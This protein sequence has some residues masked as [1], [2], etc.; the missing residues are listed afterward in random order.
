MSK[1]QK[2]TKK[3]DDN[4]NPLFYETL[5]LSYEAISIKD[6]PPFLL[7]VYDWDMGPMGDDF[8]A[9]CTISIDEAAFS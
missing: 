4:L 5:E 6:M 1:D 3:I 2:R 7:D 9:R 8:I